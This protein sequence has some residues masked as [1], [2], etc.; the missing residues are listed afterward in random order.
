MNISVAQVAFLIFIA[1]LIFAAYYLNKVRK[2]YSQMNLEYDK[3]KKL[4][5]Q[6]IK[7]GTLITGALYIVIPKDDPALLG[8][9]F[10]REAIT[11]N[12]F[13]IDTSASPISNER[14]GLLIMIETSDGRQPLFTP[15]LS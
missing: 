3:M 1:G 8:F 10:I 2:N 14:K 5:G 4:L 12:I 7:E 6:P 9:I 13:V 11:N 15:T